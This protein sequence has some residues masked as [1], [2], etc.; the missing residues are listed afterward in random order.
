[1]LLA[2]IQID[3]SLVLLGNIMFMAYLSLLI[4][5]IYLAVETHISVIFVQAAI[6]FIHL[7][8]AQTKSHI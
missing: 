8:S 2:L 3:S 1:M 4:I 6:I 5:S 7:N